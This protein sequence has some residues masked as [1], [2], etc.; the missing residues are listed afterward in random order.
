MQTWHWSH[1]TTPAGT[2]WD[3]AI[4]GD[5]QLLT[6]KGIS[7]RAALAEAETI[8]VIVDD[9]DAI[10]DF[11]R[12][13]RFYAV[14]TATTGAQLAW[15]G[16]VTD[17]HILKGDQGD[18]IFPLGTGRR[19]HVDLQ[20]ENAL[21]GFRLVTG[22][23]GVRVAEKPD[24]RLIWL[25]GSDY[26]ATVFDHGLID[27][28]GLASFPAMDA[29]DY[30]LQTAA[31]VL[32][33]ISLWTLYNHW[34]R[35][36]DTYSEIELAMFD[37]DT[38]ELDTSDLKISNDDADLAY[39]ADGNA[40]FASTGV[41]PPEVSAGYP[42]LD[43]KGDRVAF[44]LGLRYKTGVL[45]KKRLATSYEYGA[46]DQVADAPNVSSL[47]GANH[48]LDKL[49][50]Q[51]STHDERITGMRIQLA[52]EHL[53]DVRHGQRI[54][55]KQVHLAGWEDWRWARVVWKSFGRPDNESQDVYDVDLELSPEFPG[56]A[57]SA[58]L[59]YA[60]SGFYGCDPDSTY[61]DG[62]IIVG[63]Q[64]NGDAPP[65]GYRPEP[66]SGPI[67]YA[68]Y[69]PEPRGH[70]NFVGLRMLGSGRINIDHATTF[71]GVSGGSAS[72]TV[73]IRKN[74]EVIDDPAATQSRTDTV[75]GLHGFYGMFNFNLS[76]IP[77]VAGDVISVGVVFAD[78]AGFEYYAGQPAQDN[79]ST[80]LRVTGRLVA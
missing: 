14:E 79:S 33:D 44:G 2:G 8:S 40:D 64:N 3:I 70:C 27:W 7:A 49:L 56:V 39:D 55:V 68:A 4:T 11:K 35:Y 36:N 20:Q 59:L 66:L 57:V 78:W 31:D 65:A 29:A 67:E 34:I 80:H 53:N 13:H 47:S 62:A 46:I 9:P 58:A 69:A 30:T 73:T 15:N 76:D 23:D 72:I 51:H 32:R 41:Y 45:Y 71:G 24:A 19:W 52:K 48:I 28:D 21:V 26:L 25:L 43:R 1:P 10:Y 54:Q 61:G 16:Y 17:A 74:G 22:T 18:T 5:V 63:W 60:N 38:S 6:E 77:V 75:P 50:L 12:A 37:D 42:Q